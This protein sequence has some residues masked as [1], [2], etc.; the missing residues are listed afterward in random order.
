MHLHPTPAKKPKL[1]NIKTEQVQESGTLHRSIGRSTDMKTT[2]SI[3]HLYFTSGSLSPRCVFISCNIF[4]QTFFFL[5]LFYKS[6]G[7]WDQMT[8]KTAVQK[9][10]QFGDRIDTNT[11]SQQRKQ[12]RSHTQKKTK[13]N[14]LL[15]WF[16][17]N[18]HLIIPP[19]H[20]QYLIISK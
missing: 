2:E 7:R 13:K 9:N 19:P 16:D 15:I 17:Y 3:W 10:I 1:A 4:D 12:N 14:L 5:F 18:H 20:T 11:P 8:L 6:K